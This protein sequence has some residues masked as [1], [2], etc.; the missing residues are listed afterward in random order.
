M[1]VHTWR[2]LIR[3]GTKARLLR[4]G[5]RLAIG[6][7]M[8]MTVATTS[9]SGAPLAQA[10]GLGG[11]SGWQPSP[12]VCGTGNT[13]PVLIGNSSDVAQT[14]SVTVPGGL[15]ANVQIFT[16]TQNPGDAQGCGRAENMSAPGYSFNFSVAPYSSIYFW[17][18]LGGVDYNA[19]GDSHNIALG[20]LPSGIPGQGWYD[21]Q[22]SLTA[23]ESFNGLQANYEGT[24]GTNGSNQNNFNLVQCDTNT[25][26]GSVNLTSTIL[27]PYSTSDTN[28]PWYG[29]ND[30]IC[31]G[32][33][34]QGEMV[35][36]DNLSAP[37]LL[38]A[39]A[40]QINPN[41]NGFDQT[42]ISFAGN[43]GAYITAM[44]QGLWVKYENTGTPMDGQ[45][46]QLPMT[47][48][49]D[50]AFYSLSSNGDWAAVN[51]PLYGTAGGTIY[52][53][54]STVFASYSW[55]G[56]GSLPS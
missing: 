37:G 8:S 36:F 46:V 4:M 9:L 29:W 49:G 25:S 15:A 10:E 47:P 23:T 3:P 6:A 56:S 20:G 16:S 41:A 31:A 13:V 33:F 38:M 19:I 45:V 1:T 11:V 53:G 7:T 35:S 39:T 40:A 48:N 14:G 30:P 28:G 17:V 21:M 51:I 27:T 2:M 24:G 54:S 18:V 52:I 5:A 34:P 32:W 44:N 43:G 22:L 42:T 26:A 12:N 55:Q 50:G